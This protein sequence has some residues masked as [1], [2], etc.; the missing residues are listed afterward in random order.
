MRSGQ[1]IQ[2]SDDVDDDDYY[3]DD[4]DDDDVRGRMEMCVRNVRIET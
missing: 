1:F 4:V 3:C 2:P